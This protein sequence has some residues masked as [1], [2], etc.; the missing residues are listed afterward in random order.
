[1]VGV[2]DV[3][4]PLLEIEK[5]LAVAVRVVIALTTLLLGQLLHQNFPVAAVLL[6]QALQ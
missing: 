6:N 5:V 2:Q 4:L 3:P 1:V